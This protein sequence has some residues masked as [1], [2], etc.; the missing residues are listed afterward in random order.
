MTSGE[1]RVLP[2]RSMRRDE[3][4]A[5]GSIGGPVR[6]VVCREFGPVDRLAIVDGPDPAPMVGEVVVA[7]AAAAVSFV[8]GLIVQ[9]RYQVRP[10]LPF[11]PGDCGVWPRAD[12]W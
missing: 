9:G 12:G 6:R 2:E 1:P 10:E 4:A 3:H 8:D 5:R 11:S 7:V